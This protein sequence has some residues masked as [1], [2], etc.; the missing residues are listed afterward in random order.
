MY[1]TIFSQYLNKIFGIVFC[2]ASLVMIS[3]N[4]H[5]NNPLATDDTEYANYYGSKGHS[6]VQSGNDIYENF[7]SL[8]AHEPNSY[9][10]FTNATTSKTIAFAIHGGAIEPGTTEIAEGIA[11]LNHDFYSFSGT[12]GSSNA[13]LH[14]TS[15]NFDE[16]TCVNMVAACSRAISVHGA[17]GDSSVVFIGGLDDAL[18]TKI[19]KEL[20]DAGFNTN[21][22]PPQGLGGTDTNN[23]CNKT[24]TGKGVQLELTKGLREDLFSSLN[25]A[26]QGLNTQ[27]ADFYTF[28]NAIR[29]ALKPPKFWTPKDVKAPKTGS[30]SR[31]GGGTGS[32][33]ATGSGS[34]GADTGGTGSGSTNSDGTTGSGGT[35]SDGTDSDGSTSENATGAI[36]A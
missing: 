8:H 24:S 35:D 5:E 7:D 34:G 17:K 13:T 20:S 25:G 29:E 11:G 30:G 14:I 22:T 15:T 32:D 12:K 1:A 2:A 26:S 16:P 28:V 18:K 36:D 33:K 3:C 23:I 9:A 4:P 10:I 6:H 27:T 31:A 21:L 19:E